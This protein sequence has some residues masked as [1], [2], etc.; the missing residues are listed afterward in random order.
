[1]ETRFFVMNLWD[2]DEDGYAK[3]V[4]QT[5]IETEAMDR[6]KE[7]GSRAYQRER[8]DEQCHEKPISPPVELV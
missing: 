1:M 2:R 7:E 8:A 3:M 5:D 6:A 4:C